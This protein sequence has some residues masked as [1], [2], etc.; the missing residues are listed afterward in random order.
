MSIIQFLEEFVMTIGSTPTSSPVV[1]FQKRWEDIQHQVLKYASVETRKAVK[2][3]WQRY[4]EAED[5]DD[6]N[7][8]IYKF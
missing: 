6:G 2:D 4:S 1:D 3:L 8:G 5:L 7:E